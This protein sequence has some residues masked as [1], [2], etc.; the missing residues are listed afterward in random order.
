[1]LALFQ[2]CHFLSIHFLALN[3]IKLLWI[4]CAVWCGLK[5]RMQSFWKASKTRK[6]Q[7]S[8]FTDLSIA[9]HSH[10]E[11]VKSWVEYDGMV[12]KM[13]DGE[14]FFAAFLKHV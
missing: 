8:F 9:M 1:M 11:I 7:V 6:E 5:H 12:E 13:G 10:S 2:D 3:F 4:F 14:N